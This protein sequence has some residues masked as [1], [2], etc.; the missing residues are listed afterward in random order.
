[1]L[2][3]ISSPFK[4]F[5]PLAGTLYVIDRILGRISSRLRLYAYELMVQ[6]IPDKPLIP[7]R[8]ANSIKLR[9]IRL[10]DPEVERMPARADIKASRFA[11]GATCLGAFQKEK[12][13]GYIWF[14]RDKY[15]EDE[16]RCTYQL[17]PLGSAVFDFDLYLFP[18]HRMGLG[19]VALWN[20][21]NAYLHSLGIAFTFSRLTRFNLASR[22][23]HKHLGWKLV[24][25]AVFFQAWRLEFMVATQ[26]PYLGVTVQPNGRIHLVLRADALREG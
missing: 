11:Q 13:I 2:K 14:C 17:T 12:F 8:L 5:G 19:F 15:E 26:F 6:P 22:R 10:G 3:R 21:A 1:M 25:R 24:A 18:E 7:A 16:V 20:G 23:A 9:E 4:D